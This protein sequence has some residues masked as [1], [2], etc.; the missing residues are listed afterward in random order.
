MQIHVTLPIT[1]HGKPYLAKFSTDSLI[2]DGCFTTKN[3]VNGSKSICMRNKPSFVV[4]NRMLLG[5]PTP[6]EP[7]LLQNK[8]TAHDTIEL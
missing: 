4:I 5:M 8:M 6:L 3:A 7:L 2:F 1:Q